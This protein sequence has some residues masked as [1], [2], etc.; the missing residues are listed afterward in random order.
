[1]PYRMQLF[2]DIS[3]LLKPL[4]DYAGILLHIKKNLSAEMSPIIVVG[5]SYGGM[6]AAWFRLKYP[7]IAL[8][9]VAS[10]APILYF[11]NITPSN[12]YYDLVSK[13]F[14]EGSESCYKTIKQSWAEIDKVRH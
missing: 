11:D 3:T 12:A 7:H 10:S 8:G 4:A 5:A 9:A 1:M 2:V 6:L 13:D 14:R